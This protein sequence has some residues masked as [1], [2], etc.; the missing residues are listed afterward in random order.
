VVAHVV[1]VNTG[2]GPSNLTTG[3]QG[4]K[5]ADTR[6]RHYTRSVRPCQRIAEYEARQ[7]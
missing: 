1:A 3:H 7:A 4:F 2:G 6:S 5:P